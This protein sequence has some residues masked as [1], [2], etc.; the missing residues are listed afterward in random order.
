MTV[1]LVRKLFRDIRVA[2]VVVGILLAGFQCLWAKVTERITAELVPFF[3]ERI[4]LDLVKS[5]LFAGPGKVMQT[6][7]G[8]ETIN[9]DRALDMLSV[10]YVHPLMQAVFCVWAVGRAGGAVA[11][12]IN[13]GTMELLMAQP[14]PRYRLILA[15]FCVDLMT[16]PMLCLCLWSGTWLGASLT[17][18]LQLDAPTGPNVLHVDPTVFGPAL[19]S[20]AALMFA[21]SGYTIGLSAGGRSQ[22]RVLGIAVLVTLVQFL[23]NVVGQM[24][25][26]VSYLRPFTV[27]YYFQPQQVILKHQWSVDLGKAFHW[28]EPLT[29]NAILVLVGVGAIGYGMALWTFCRRD[30]PAPL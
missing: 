12:E 15:H 9:L 13:R 17:G 7:M 20:V 4:G 26:T 14:M 29:I 11:G 25:E 8:G 3:S 24:W 18:I 30:L 27:F 5:V 22:A 28:S 21:V 10:G 16:L 23:I 19:L 2:L 6:L 1:T